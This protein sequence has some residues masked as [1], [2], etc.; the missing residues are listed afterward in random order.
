MRRWAAGSRDSNRGFFRRTGMLGHICIPEDVRTFRAVKR[1]QRLH[2]RTSAKKLSH[3]VAAVFSVPRESAAPAELARP[4]RLRRSA[5]AEHTT[6]GNY[7]VASS[8]SRSRH[9]LATFTSRRASG[10]FFEG[11]SR[12]RADTVDQTVRCSC[13]TLMCVLRRHGQAFLEAW[14]RP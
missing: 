6:E 2:N 7:G 5:L 1:C 14:R 13:G 4:R 3:S 8:E 9:G 11:A 10:R 12:L